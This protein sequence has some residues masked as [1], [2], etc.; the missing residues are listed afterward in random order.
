[1]SDKHMNTWIVAA[2]FHPSIKYLESLCKILEC[3][4]TQ[5][6]HEGI[7]DIL[8]DLED[9]RSIPSL[10]KALTHEFDFDPWRHL[11][12]KILETLYVIDTPK[13]F[14]IIKRFLRSSSPELRKR[15]NI[16]C[17]KG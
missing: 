16:L 9:E 8:F 17:G 4:S 3:D 6:W 1:M 7:V 2:Q 12:V 10:E 13:A 5:I 14:E 15:A 11:G